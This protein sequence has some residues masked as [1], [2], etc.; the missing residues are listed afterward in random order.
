MKIRSL[1]NFC[2]HAP[3]PD[4]LR[5][6]FSAPDSFLTANNLSIAQESKFKR[7]LYDAELVDR[8]SRTPT[9]FTALAK[10]IG[11]NQAKTWGL[12]LVNLVCNNPQVRHYVEDFPI[13][14]E[15][16][17]AEAEKIFQAHGMSFRSS[18]SIV[19]SYKR[20]CLTPLGTELHFGA[21][22]SIGKKLSTLKRT[23]GKVDDGRIILYALYKFAEAIDR[24]QFRLSF[25][26]SESKL[27]GVSP[28]KIFGIE[29][30]EMTQFLNG[31]STNYP[32][33]INATFTHDLEKISLVAEKTSQ[34]VLKLFDR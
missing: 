21:T 33:F 13:D 34:D 10:K 18:R 8:K 12:I 16:A 3:K 22:V 32:D 28:A 2:D 15:I 25:L 6:F 26:M 23:K 17:R 5:D 24:Y 11:W 27:E 9:D 7:F 20:F 14:E 29:R 19:S 1:N 4:W 31:L 30:E